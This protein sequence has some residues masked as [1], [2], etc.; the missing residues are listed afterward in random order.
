MRKFQVCLLVLCLILTTTWAQENYPFYDV[1]HGLFSPGPQ[2]RVY[3][4]N[5]DYG[6]QQQPQQYPYYSDGVDRYQY[7]APPEN[8]DNEYEHHPQH[9]HSFYF[10]R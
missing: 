10:N 3:Y 1:F 4:Y 2:S 9:H 5:N 7:Q 6:Q 8:L